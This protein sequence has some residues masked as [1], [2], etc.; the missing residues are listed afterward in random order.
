MELTVATLALI[1][2]VATLGITVAVAFYV[3]AASSTGQCAKS[4]KNAASQFCHRIG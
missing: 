2:I 1:A 3:E 4:L